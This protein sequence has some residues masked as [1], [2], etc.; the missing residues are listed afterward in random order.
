MDESIKEQIQDM[1]TTFLGEIPF[2]YKLEEAI[3]NV[4]LLLKTLFAMKVEEEIL[5]KI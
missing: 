3:G 1:N 5:N 2:D 4:N